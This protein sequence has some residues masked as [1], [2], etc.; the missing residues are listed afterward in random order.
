MFAVHSWNEENIVMRNTSIDSDSVMIQDSDS[1]E[2][3]K[4]LLTVDNSLV[5][6]A[7]VTLRFIVPLKM[8]YIHGLYQN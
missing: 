1:K 8:F 2:G 6:P 4:R 7:K 5:L 3:D